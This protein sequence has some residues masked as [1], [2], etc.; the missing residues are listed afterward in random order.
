M[1]QSENVFKHILN[2]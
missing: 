1:T 2:R